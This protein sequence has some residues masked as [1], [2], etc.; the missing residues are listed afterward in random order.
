MSSGAGLARKLSFFGRNDAGT[1]QNAGMWLNGSDSASRGKQ[2]KWGNGE[3][4][5]TDGA[6]TKKSR[7][8]RKP[9]NK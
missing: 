1:G 3:T 5:E 6:T 7:I 8:R 2:G 9:E 4:E